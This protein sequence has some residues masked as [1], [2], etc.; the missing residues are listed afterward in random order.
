MDN[1]KLP[2]AKFSLNIPE[3]TQ[4]INIYE[5]KALEPRPPVK[6][7]LF[8]LID[9]PQEFYLKRKHTLDKDTCYVLVDDNGIKFVFNDKDPWESGYVQGVLKMSVECQQWGINNENVLYQA[10]ELARLIKKNEYLFDK[11]EEWTAIYNALM[12]FNANVKINLTDVKTTEGDMEKA[13]KVTIEK[14]IPK[15]F[16]L[17]TKIFGSEKHKY[18]VDLGSEFISKEVKFYLDSSDLAFMI[19]QLTEK[20]LKDY[21]KEFE[22]DEIPI[23][24]I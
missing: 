14:N 2:T 10:K 16:T 24:H 7:E 8:G 21:V 3:G 4:S 6:I 23:I 17:N 13:Y 11:K 15:G 20:Y 19:S 9:S 12:R 22:K 18:W 5:G 1:I